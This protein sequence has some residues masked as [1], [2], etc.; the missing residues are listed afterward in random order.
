MFLKT[1]NVEIKHINNLNFQ[2]VNSKNFPSIKLLN[3][4]FTLGLSTP[5]I[6]N[7]ANEVSS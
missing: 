7:A 6:I 1:S 5:I 4:C 2:K 3:K